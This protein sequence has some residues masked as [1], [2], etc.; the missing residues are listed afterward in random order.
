MTETEEKKWNVPQDI[1]KAAQ[2]VESR[3][4][5]EH[6]T[7]TK[8]FIYKM[9]ILALILGKIDPRAE[10]HEEMKREVVLDII[11]LKK[12]TKLEGNHT[13]KE[14]RNICNDIRL[15]GTEF[16]VDGQ[17]R[18]VINWISSAEL[19]EGDKQVKFTLSPEI[20]PLI[21]GFLPHLK[22]P[23]VK[24]ELDVVLQF[25]RY[26][27]MKLY[28]HIIKEKYR[29]KFS[30]TIQETIDYLGLNNTKS[31]NKPGSLRQLV[32]LPTCKEISEKSPYSVELQ[33]D[34]IG[35]R[36]V[37]GYTFIIVTKKTT[38]KNKKKLVA[39]NSTV[40]KPAESLSELKEL[41]T[42]EKLNELFLEYC[43]QNNLKVENKLDIQVAA[44]GFKNYAYDKYKISVMFK[45]GV[46]ELIG[47]AKDAVEIENPG[48]TSMSFDESSSVNS[49][50]ISDEQKKFIKSLM[51]QTGFPFSIGLDQLF[52][53]QA[54]QIIGVLTELK[55]NNIEEGEAIM[56][57]SALI[58]K[59][60]Q[61]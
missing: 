26:S 53:S 6:N 31:F 29:G 8:K 22:L 19:I 54:S 16:Y 38:T 40:K 49:S 59:K 60:K 39:G 43:D 11:E 28:E 55:S 14:I 15:L 32:L 18:K 37:K 20:M 61:L 35:L 13:K 33:T 27:S 44:M 30:W 5:V 34:T 58:K 48:Q 4:A 46:W 24:L 10:T 51:K 57:I 12:Q 23:F 1:V 41:Y 42:Y 25:R 47:N 3:W 2:L 50:L 36:K 17:W 21:T 52:K 7:N 56:S 45:E 9:R